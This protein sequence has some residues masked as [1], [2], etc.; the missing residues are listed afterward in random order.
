LDV[1]TLLSIDFGPGQTNPTIGSLVLNAAVPS[2]DLASP[3]GLELSGINLDETEVINDVY[4]NVSQIS[5]Y[6]LFINITTNTAYQYDIRVMQRAARGAW[7]T[8]HYQWSSSPAYLLREYSIENP[9]GAGS[10]NRLRIQDITSGTVEWMF[11]Y[12][13]DISGWTVTLPANLGTIQLISTNHAATA[14]TAIKRYLDS[15]GNIIAQRS[16]IFTNLA[17]G[18]V[19]LSD[20]QGIGVETRSTQWTYYE[21]ASSAGYAVSVDRPAIKTEVNAD[22]SWRQVLS[23]DTK[24]HVTSELRGIDTGVTTDSSLCRKVMYTYNLNAVR[25]PNTPRTVQ[26]Y[27]KDILIRTNTE[28]Y[29]SDSEGDHHR[30]TQYANTADPS[31]TA[32]VVTEDIFHTGTTIP[33]RTINPDR[34]V[35]ITTNSTASDG[36]QTNTTDL[37]QYSGGIVMNGTRTVEVTRPTGTLASRQVWRLAG[38]TPG[39]QIE[40]AVYSN[41]DDFD[42]PQRVDYLEGLYETMTNACC[43]FYS[44]TDTDGVTTTYSYDVLGR[45]Y[46]STRLGITTQNILDTAGRFLVQQR[47][48]T[49]NSVMTLSGEAYDTSGFIIRETNALSGVTRFTRTQT[50]AGYD[51]TTTVY[52]DAGYKIE[53]INGEGLA[54]VTGTAVAPV[55]YPNGVMVVSYNNNANRTLKYHGEIKLNAAFNDTSEQVTNCVD[56]LGR[57]IISIWPDPVTG[58]DYSYSYFDNNGHLSKQ[59]DADGVTTLYRYD[60]EGRLAVTAIDVDHDGYV[61]DYDLGHSGSDRVTQTITSYLDA[62]SSG[63]GMPIRRVETTVWT[64]PGSS[65]TAKVDTKE[66][67]LDGLFT[68][69]TQ[70]KDQSTLVTMS[71]GRTLPSSGTSDVTTTNADQSS[72]L[73][74]IVNGRVDSVTLCDSGGSPVGRT[75]YQYDVHGHTWKITDARNGTTTYAYNNADQVTKVTSPPGPYGSPLVTVTG[76]D[77]MGR[78]SS[79]TQPD[80]TVVNNEYYASG[81]LKRTYGSRTFPVAY[82]YDAQGRVT[83]MTNWSSFSASGSSAGTRVT[84]WN[85]NPLRGWLDNK[86]YPDAST[87]NPSSVGTSYTYTSGG[88]LKTRTWARGVLTTY[89]YGFDAGNGYGDVLGI[90]YSSDPQ[91]TPAVAYTY[92]RRGRRGSAAMASGMSIAYNYNDADLSIGESYTGS[93]LGG[94]STSIVYDNSLRRS[95]FSTAGLSPTLS[96]SYGYDT[97][98]R[99]QSVSSGAYAATYSYLPNSRLVGYITFNNGA[100]AP[101][102]TVRQYDNLNRLQSAVSTPSADQP[103][104][105]TYQNNMANQRTRVTLQDGC[106]WFYQYDSLGQVKSG[107]KYWPDGTPVAGQQFEYAHDDIGN[108]TQTKTGGDGNGWNLRVANYTSDK[109]NRYNSRDVP[110]YAN[111]LGLA[112]GNEAVTVTGLPDAVNN[113]DAPYRKVEYFRKELAFNNSTTPLWE[114]VTVT[115]PGEPNGAG[116]I[117]VPGNP[118]SFGYD[119]DGNLTSDGRWAYTWDA[120]NRLINMTANTPPQLI[121][122]GYDA[123]GRRITKKVWNNTGRIGIPTLNLTYLYDNWNLVA[124]LDANNNSV[125]KRSYLW[126]LDLSGTLQGAGGVGGLIAMKTYD[127]PSQTHFFA[128]DGNGSVVKLVNAADGTVSAQYDYGP[129]GEV[130]RATGPMAKMNPLRFSTKYQDD[131]SDLLYYGYRYYNPSTGRWPN[132]DPFGEPGFGVTRRQPPSL[133][134]G[135][136]NRYLFVVN[137]PMNGVD[138]L[139]LGTWHFNVYKQGTPDIGVDVYYKMDDEQKCLCSKAVVDRWVKKFLGI[140]P[141]T[142]GN[143]YPDSAGLGG[144]WDPEDQ[145]AHAEGDSPDGPLAIWPLQWHKPWAFAFKFYARCTAG[146]ASGEELSTAEKNYHTSG[147]WSGDGWYGYWY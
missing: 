81:L 55:R 87:G 70:Y 69:D 143:Y 8:D 80:G 146:P 16:Q 32:N 92:D 43:G 108:R 61:A 82:N 67:S 17:W 132:R 71:S 52:P 103:A 136:P 24:G 131:E 127:V 22:G 42:R 107:K 72:T 4:Q 20:S 26:E 65:T 113:S 57:Q 27:W 101:L 19:M 54:N 84:S 11:V 51:I 122:V 142:T 137:N 118:E 99:I 1:G 34:T 48:G 109:L 21:T 46:T 75:S 10:N 134:A 15:S 49:D 39:V 124:E 105:F 139:G 141:G 33:I 79:V 56:G 100:N 9:D 30:T 2:T 135:G 117:F 53:E 64:T 74:H 77:S 130:I 88:R 85:Y 120:E 63:R 95:T 133:L 3:R 14:W 38:G 58:Y 25:D 86:R 104:S 18:Q 60:N 91:N 145:T 125:L 102:S 47:I 78:V 41:F 6:Y 5:T 36:T 73:T 140:W 7:V 45:Q 50:T 31:D 90:T 96:Y 83:F 126:G 35:T 66:S 93:P 111:V 89:T 28:T 68:W 12:S 115:A 147:H 144:Y 129:F 76:Y 106:Y 97:A 94:L 114:T 119:T 40:S 98:G 112:L 110:R 44:I 123:T 37:G 116:K 59:V 29:F 138:I 23:Y 128:C 121:D 62:G 13:T